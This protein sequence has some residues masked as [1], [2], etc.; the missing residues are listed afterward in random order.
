[1]N[2]KP[3]SLDVENI[4]SSS[5]ISL[6]SEELLDAWIKR[7]ASAISIDQWIYWNNSP[8]RHASS[9]VLTSFFPAL[10]SEIFVKDSRVSSYV[11]DLLR[12]RLSWNSSISW[13]PQDPLWDLGMIPSDRFQRLAFLSASFSLKHE[14]TQIIDGS[15]V[16]K[17][18][19]EIGEDIFQFVLLSNT[20]S[21]YFLKPLHLELSKLVIDDISEAI[22]QGA[23]M[24]VGHAFSSKEQG[25][26]ERIA[27]KFPGS[28]PQ[29]YCDAPLPWASE[30]EKILSALWK[31]SGSWL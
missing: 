1:M 3:E 28:F 31:D 25:I 23:K 8:L 13:A 16:R 30:A 17:L 19:K 5:S 15:I 11:D 7:D 6:W 18:R 14:I 10:F 4:A 22:Q 29:G 12:V 9:E 20:S 24:I 21:K 27:T 26:Q 2:S